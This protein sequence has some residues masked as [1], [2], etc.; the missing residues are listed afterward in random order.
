MKESLRIKVFR[1]NILLIAVALI[2]FAVL[3]VLQV[4]RYADL[5]EDTSRNQSAVIMDTMS[6]SMRDMATGR[7]VVDAISRTE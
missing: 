6:S 7:P 1:M 4:R 3:G 2:M 5:M